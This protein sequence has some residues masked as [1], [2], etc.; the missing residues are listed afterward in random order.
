MAGRAIALIGL[1]AN[2]M[3]TQQKRQKKRLP[4]TLQVFE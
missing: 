1:G 2:H 3:K 4:T